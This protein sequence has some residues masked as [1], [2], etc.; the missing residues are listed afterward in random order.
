[1]NLQDILWPKDG[2]CTDMEMYFH[3][4]YKI[5]LIKKE[6][7]REGTCILFRRGG[8]VTTDTYFNSLSVEKWKKYT[9][10]QDVSLTLTVQGSFLVSLCWKQK[11]NGTYIERELKNTVIEA[12]ERSEVTLDFPDETKGMFFFRIEALKKDGKFY[13]GYYS[14]NTEPDKCRPIKLGI[15]ICTF[16]R[17]KYVRDNIRL[18]NEEIIENENS[19]LFGRLEV[20]ISDNGQSLGEYRLS[21]DKVHVVNNKNAGGA[22]GFTRGLMEIIKRP[23]RNGITHALLMDDDV[24]IDTASIVKTAALLSLLK[25]A[26]KDAF[27]GGAMLR[28]DQRNIQV[29]SGASWNAGNLISLKAGLDL[30]LWQNCLKNEQE[31]YREFNAWWY[32]CFP[33]ELV[34]KDNLPLPIFIRG[35]DLEYGLRNM[36]TLILMNGICVWHEPFENKYSSFLEYYVIRNRLIDNAYHFLWWGKKQLIKCLMGEYRRE[37]YL[38]RYRNVELYIRGIRDFL[39]GIDFLEHTDPEQLHKDIM[40]SGYKALPSEQLEVPFMDSEYE[41][42][43]TE[44]HPRLHEIVRKFSLNGYLLPAKHIRTVPMAQPRPEFVWRAKTILFYDIVENKGFVTHR[45]IRKFIAQGFQ[46][47]G[48]IVAILARYDRAKQ[49]YIDRVREITCTEFWEKYLGIKEQ[50][51]CEG[52][53]DLDGY[54]KD[55][56]CTE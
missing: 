11:I 19:P 23:D 39:K 51:P 36:K 13:G 14:T 49:S 26:Y 3:S 45:S 44:E 53:E 6:D 22:G 56:S 47:L 10:I 1:M 15:V 28:A 30:R 2:I 35:D 18:L 25:E 41:R 38:Y 5:N 4:N 29:E 20:F 33:M 12:P 42:G 17:E 55:A 52:M 40:A 7:K 24:V 37:G 43:R 27:V 34:R 46:V 32:C 54:T 9:E 21:S 16:R 50:K 48:T 31:E 8:V